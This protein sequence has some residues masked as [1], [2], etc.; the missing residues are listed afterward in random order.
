MRLGRRDDDGGLDLSGEIFVLG[1]E[2]GVGDAQ[3]PGGFEAFAIQLGHV[4]FDGQGM[5]DAQVVG[6]PAPDAKQ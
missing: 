2:A 4:K 1:G 6:A 5:E 3:L